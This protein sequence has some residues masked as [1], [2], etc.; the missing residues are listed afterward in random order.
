[1]VRGIFARA[2]GQLAIGVG[3]GAVLASVLL[4]ADG[5]LTLVAVSGVM[6]LV[7]LLASVGP[8]RRTL[9]FQPTEALKEG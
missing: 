1:V 9:R 4:R 5:P 2:L 6:L 8:T 3:A 7:G